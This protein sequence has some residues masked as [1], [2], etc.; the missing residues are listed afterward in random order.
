MSFG[1]KTLIWL[2]VIA[3]IALLAVCSSRFIERASVQSFIKQHSQYTENQQHDDRNIKLSLGALWALQPNASLT[4]EDGTVITA[5]D[6]EE[7]T[8]RH[9][10]YKKPYSFDGTEDCEFVAA[11]TALLLIDMTDNGPVLYEVRYAANELALGPKGRNCTWESLIAYG[12]IGMTNENTMAITG[13]GMFKVML[14]NQL[15][16]LSG[17]L[18]MSGSYEIAD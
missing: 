11:C 1:K 17:T 5:L 9:F 16:W 10:E 14:G 7:D 2:A 6:S 8:N 4:L 15:Y 18:S 3:I 12:G 13:T